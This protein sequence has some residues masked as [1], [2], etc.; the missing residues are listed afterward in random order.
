[1]NTPDESIEQEGESIE[2]Q[3]DKV[4]ANVKANGEIID[5]IANDTAKIKEEQENKKEE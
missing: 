2:Q 3:L 1:M 4:I 5:E